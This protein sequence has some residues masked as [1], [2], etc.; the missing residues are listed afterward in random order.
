MKALPNNPKGFSLLEMIA[1]MAAGMV[2]M[3]SIYTA[4]INH[5]RSHVTQQLVVEMQQNARAAMNLMKRE[6]RMAGYDPVATD[7]VNNDAT[8]GIDDETSGAAMINAED[9]NISFSADISYNGLIDNLANEEITYWLDGTT[10]RRQDKGQSG[11]PSGGQIIAYDIEAVAFAYAVDNE[12]LGDPDGEIDTT[13]NGHIRWFFDSNDGDNA[14]DQTLAIEGDALSDNGVIDIDDPE[15]GVNWGGA[16][17]NMDRIRA[18]RIWLLART[19]QPIKG[20]TDNRTYAVG[21]IHVG[22]GDGDWEPGKRRVLLTATVYCRN[23]K[24]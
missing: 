18:I 7:G 13:A 8:G 14:V 11:P 4:Y 21:P 2:V 5:Q 15:G 19:R 23:L 22:P 1:A 3:V 20:H 12:P 17:I 9:D 24:D 16:Q 6:I 10:L